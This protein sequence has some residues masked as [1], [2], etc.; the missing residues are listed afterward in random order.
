MSI[1]VNCGQEEGI[2][3]SRVLFNFG[4]D[5]R[6]I[7][8]HEWR[9][10]TKGWPVLETRIF[11]RCQRRLLGQLRFYPKP[12][13]PC[14]KSRLGFLLAAGKAE[15]RWNLSKNEQ[16]KKYR[17]YACFCDDFLLKFLSSYISPSAIFINLE[18]S[19]A[20]F[21]KIAKPILVPTFRA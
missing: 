16:E 17:N 3:F 12:S 10:S 7:W 9:K 8:H 6:H 21:G 11:S 18:S 2:R 20:L 19:S 15:M 14:L 4:H 13:Q 5:S 1:W